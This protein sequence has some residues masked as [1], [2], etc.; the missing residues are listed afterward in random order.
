M[1][2]WNFWGEAEIL[3]T[4]LAS[5]LPADSLESK[6]LSYKTSW[7]ARKRQRIAPLHLMQQ[8]NFQFILRHPPITSM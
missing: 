1:V 2:K 6:R 4:A 3:G 7:N 5:E 8:W